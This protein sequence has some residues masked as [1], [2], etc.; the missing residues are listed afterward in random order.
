[1]PPSTIRPRQKIGKYRIERKMAEGGFAHVY[2]AMDTIEGV[3]VAVKVPFEKFI[4]NEL[5]QTFRQEVRLVAKL[6]HPNVLPLK[7]AQLDRW[8]FCHCVIAGSADA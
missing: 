8:A 5:F 3:R 6:D 7:D 1:M 2:A 4:S